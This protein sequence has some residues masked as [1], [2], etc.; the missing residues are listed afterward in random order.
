LTWPDGCQGRRTFGHPG[1]QVHKPIRSSA[2][3]Q[4]CDSARADVLLELNPFVEGKKDLKTRCLGQR[5][6]LTVPLAREACFG[7]GLTFMSRQRIL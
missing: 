1:T 6:Q 4:D 7:C 2:D 5:Q 3:Y